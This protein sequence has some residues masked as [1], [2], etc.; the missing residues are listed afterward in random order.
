VCVC[1]CVCVCSPFPSF[2]FADV[3]LLISCIFIGVVNILG[4]E[5]SLEY[6]L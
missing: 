1:V 4:L 2:R 3:E 6:L 5:F